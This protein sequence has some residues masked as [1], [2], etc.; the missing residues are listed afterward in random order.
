MSTQDICY[1][2]SLTVRRI[3]YTVVQHAHENIITSLNNDE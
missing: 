2:G 1:D 3:L